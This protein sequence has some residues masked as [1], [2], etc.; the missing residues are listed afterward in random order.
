MSRKC[1]KCGGEETKWV[2]VVESGSFAMA[3]AMGSVAQVWSVASTLQSSS[4][5]AGE[6]RVPFGA[7][8]GSDVGGCVRAGAG[9]QKA[10]SVG[11]VGVVRAALGGSRGGSSVL[12]RPKLDQ[13]GSDTAPQTEEGGE[14][15]KDRQR[16]RTGGGDRYRVLLLDAEHHTESYVEKTLPKAVP[17]VT[18]EQARKC[19]LE[20]R[21]FG[22]S[23]VMVAVKVR[24]SHPF[25]QKAYK[26]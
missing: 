10:T 24:T 6:S 5:G 3:V 14:S 17:G 7:S 4:G 2:V 1:E 11:S 23:V 13:S 26:I 9:T 15:G 25:T 21:L 19:C 18:P 8:G 22:K 12:E 20:A 16:V